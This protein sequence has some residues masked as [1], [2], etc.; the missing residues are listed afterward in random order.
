MYVSAVSGGIN[1]VLVAFDPSVIPPSIGPMRVVCGLSIDKKN[2]H[3]LFKRQILLDEPEIQIKNSLLL[4]SENVEDMDTDTIV[5]G[6][7]LVTWAPFSAAPVHLAGDIPISTYITPDTVYSYTLPMHVPDANGL[8]NAMA[9]MKSCNDDAT[10]QIHRGPNTAYQKYYIPIMFHVN[11]RNNYAGMS[12]NIHWYT[13]SHYA[14]Y[15]FDQYMYRNV[16]RHYRTVL[17]ISLASALKHNGPAAYPNIYRSTDF[18]NN[19]SSSKTPEK[20]ILVKVISCRDAWGKWSADPLDWCYMTMERHVTANPV[21]DAALA[22]VVYPP[23]GDV[24]GTNMISLWKDQCKTVV[25]SAVS[26]CWDHAITEVAK[27][28]RS[29]SLVQSRLNITSMIRHPDTDA[30]FH[31]S[32]PKNIT[33]STSYATLGTG[34]FELVTEPV[35]CYNLTHH[36]AQAK[37]LSLVKAWSSEVSKVFHAGQPDNAQARSATLMEQRLLLTSYIM[38]LGAGFDLDLQHPLRTDDSR[39]FW[40]LMYTLYPGNRTQGNSV[41]HKDSPLP[42]CYSVGHIPSPA[43][44]SPSVTATESEFNVCGPQ[45]AYFHIVHRVDLHAFD[46]AYPIG[47]MFWASD[48][49]VAD[50][51]VFIATEH[52][53]SIFRDRQY[54]PAYNKKAP[55]VPRLTH[56]NK[57]VVA[58]AHYYTTYTEHVDTFFIF[59]H[60]IQHPD[61]CEPYFPREIWQL[62]K[63]MYFT[64]LQIESLSRTMFTI[65]PLNFPYAW[66]YE[67]DMSYLSANVGMDEAFF[68]HGQK[69]GPRAVRGEGLEMERL[70][71]EMYSW[72]LYEDE[73]E[74][75]EDPWRDSYTNPLVRTVDLLIHGKWVTVRKFLDSALKPDSEMHNASTDSSALSTASSSSSSSSSSASNVDAELIDFFGPEIVVE[76]RVQEEES[77]YEEIDLSAYEVGLGLPSN[78]ELPVQDEPKIVEEEEEITNLGFIDAFELLPIAEPVLPAHPYPVVGSVWRSFNVIDLVVMESNPD[79]PTSV[80]CQ[81]LGVTKK[82]IVCVRLESF[83]TFFSYEREAYEERDRP[84]ADEPEAKRQ[85]K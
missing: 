73:E 64:L 85:K 9:Q 46:M 74:D 49:I 21:E 43:A 20:E 84:K 81:Y 24:I 7:A 80:I 67:P 22:Q 77:S 68:Q 69:E 42:T 40:D 41:H 83:Y 29:F 79:Y 36:P 16:T 2:R 78:I 25:Q 61:I 3:P 39:S 66:R 17:D 15:Q 65:P 75:T 48:K 44:A 58:L 10:M 35:M 4:Y 6:L 18:S 54:D 70:F 19:T 31:F 5:N 76:H 52:Y 62:I 57:N 26:G 56:A 53:K 34:H 30:T 32:Y 13:A 50:D 51:G 11:S 45:F 27:Q 14:K 60:C 38:A 23:D 33:M 47:T 59:S 72:E 12:N 55:R 28:K 63:H 1:R 37:Y 82:H 71:P 8:R